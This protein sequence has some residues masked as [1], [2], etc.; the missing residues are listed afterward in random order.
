MFEPLSHPSFPNAQ[1]SGLNV[2]S[3]PEHNTNLVSFFTH[4]AVKLSLP[5][6]IYACIFILMGEAEVRD[7]FPENTPKSVT[8]KPN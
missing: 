6:W 2:F 3:S 5:F 1:C 8:L 7:L 4:V